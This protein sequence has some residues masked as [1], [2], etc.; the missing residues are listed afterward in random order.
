MEAAAAKPA[1]IGRNAGMA[2]SA[3]SIVGIGDT[4]LGDSGSLLKAAVP[5]GAGAGEAGGRSPPEG[6]VG[7][8]SADLPGTAAVE[9]GG[10]VSGAIG[11]TGVGAGKGDGTGGFGAERSESSGVTLMVGEKGLTRGGLVDDISELAWVDALQSFVATFEFLKR[12]DDCFGHAAVGL[13]RAADEHKLFA[14]GD[15][16]VAVVIVEA[17][18]NQ[19]G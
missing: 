16:F 12:L 9:T 13:F 2:S 18:A 6:G 11:A 5:L 1:T 4:N 10:V 8:L 14:L 17:D 15:S 3:C 7:S 19:A